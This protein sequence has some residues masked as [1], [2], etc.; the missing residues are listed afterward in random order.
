M[1]VRFFLKSPR[2]FQECHGWW[3]SAYYFIALL[4][5]LDLVHVAVPVFFLFFVL[6][7][8]VMRILLLSWFLFPV[9]RRLHSAT[10]GTDVG[11]KSLTF[12]Q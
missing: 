4:S 8:C 11:F 5:L 3:F 7:Y 10:K 1:H 9:M 2:N 6:V 12:N